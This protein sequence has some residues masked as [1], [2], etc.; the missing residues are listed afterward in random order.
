M[1]VKVVHELPEELSIQRR[2]TTLHGGNLFAS[3]KSHENN[4]HFL[5]I[6]PA[7]SRESIEW[8]SIPPLPFHLRAF[9]V[10]PTNGILAVA[11]E[12]ERWVPSPF[13]TSCL[14]SDR[15]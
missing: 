5:R 9:V 8:W 4:L 1:V 2:Y 3:H 7:T 15:A 12:K 10:Y 11:E 6:P 13:G 14:A